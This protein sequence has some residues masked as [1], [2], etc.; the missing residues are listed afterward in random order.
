M[1]IPFKN[2]F[3]LAPMLEPNDIA[4]RI[5]CKKSGAGEVYHGMIN[6]LS[7]KKL[8][9]QDKPVLQIFCKETRGIKEFVKKYDSQVSGWD[10][11]LGCPS[12]VAKRIKVGS[13]MQEEFDKIEEILKEI[14]RTTKKFFSVKIRKSEYSYKI[15]KIA[16]KYCDA[17]I[18][19]PRTREQGYSGKADIKFALELKKKSKIPIGYSGD[20]DE[21]NAKKLLKNF[22]FVMIGRTAIGNP[23]IFEVLSESKKRF[24][25]KDYLKLAEKHKIS[26]KQIKFQSFNFTKG[27]KNA[28]KLRLGL[29]QAKSVEELKEIYFSPKL[30]S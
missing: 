25:F 28:T 27:M 2:K 13:Y 8:S 15:L 18:I 1:K 17:L 6:P 20:V 3:I 29:M 11:N 22:D 9:L 5:L 30:I 4:F 24:S 26:F 21:K 7:K 10:F 14:R 12:V 19:H 23:K 16:E